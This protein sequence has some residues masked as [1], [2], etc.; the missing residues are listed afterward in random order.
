[1]IW[2]SHDPRFIIQDEYDEFFGIYGYSFP[3][4]VFSS[5]IAVWRVIKI[6]NENEKYNYRRYVESW[7]GKKGD[8]KTMSF[9]NSRFHPVISAIREAELASEEENNALED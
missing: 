7:K 4:I 8:V 2:H 6:H 1:M 3:H 5:T 9:Y